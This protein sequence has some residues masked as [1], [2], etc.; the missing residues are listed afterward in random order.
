M[1]ACI[2]GE[3]MRE[4]MQMMGEGGREDEGKINQLL[5]VRY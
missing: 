5:K 3:T 2:G 4:L 1:K